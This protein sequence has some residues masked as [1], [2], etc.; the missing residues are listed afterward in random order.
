VELQASIGWGR[1]FKGFCATEIQNVVNTQ[2]EA[3][4]NRFEQLQWTSEVIQRVWDYKAEHWKTQNSNKHGH[5][6][7]ETN[8]NKRKHLLAIARDLIQNTTP[9]TTQTQKDVPSLL[10]TNQKAHAKPQNLGHYN[11]TNSPLPSQCKQSSRRQP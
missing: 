3:P 7:A 6:P 4:L 9:A 10:K 1:F 8:S 11:A 5:M 2:R